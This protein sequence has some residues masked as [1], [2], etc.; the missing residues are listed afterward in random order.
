MSRPID[1]DKMKNFFKGNNEA[2][3]FFHTLID[4]QPTID[5]A[6]VVHAHWIVKGD[7]DMDNEMYHCSKCGEEQ[8]FDNYYEQEKFPYCPMCGAKMDERVDE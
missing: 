5:V 4:A 7:D 1:A 2:V 6:P 8:F 3:K